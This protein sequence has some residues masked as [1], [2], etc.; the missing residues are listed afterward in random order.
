MFAFA[1][2]L[3]TLLSPSFEPL[4]AANPPSVVR[5]AFAPDPLTAIDAWLKLYRSGKIA[6]ESKDNIAKHSLAMKFD[7]T[8]KSGLGVPTWEGD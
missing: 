1:T 8:G 5:S 4:P 6:Y 2:A 7:L 3:L